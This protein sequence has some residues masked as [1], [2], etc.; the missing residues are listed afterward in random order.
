MCN[1][2]AKALVVFV[3]MGRAPDP[4]GFYRVLH[5][6]PRTPSRTCTDK[7]KRARLKFVRFL[8]V[9]H[10]MFMD[11]MERIVYNRHETFSFQ[12]TYVTE[13]V[14]A[15]DAKRVA[16]AMSVLAN[17]DSRRPYDARC[18]PMFVVWRVTLSLSFAVNLCD[19]TKPWI[20]SS[21]STLARLV[22]SN[23]AIFA[24]IVCC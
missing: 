15:P 8:I 22:L 3:V 21:L 12:A 1:D 20:T 11:K 10:H 2:S 13:L 4:G 5:A 6:S 9:G 7:C 18:A 17:P 14:A 19:T 16:H 24:C 23:A